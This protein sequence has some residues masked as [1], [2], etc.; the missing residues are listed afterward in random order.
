MI[1]SRDFRRVQQLHGPSWLYSNGSLP[2]SWAHRRCALPGHP[3]QVQHDVW[4]KK[5]QFLALLS[6]V[7]QNNLVQFIFISPRGGQAWEETALQLYLLLCMFC[8]E[9]TSASSVSYFSMWSWFVQANFFLIV[10]HTLSDWGGWVLVTRCF[11]NLQ[12]MTLILW[13]QVLEQAWFLYLVAKRVFSL[14]SE[15]VKLPPEKA[16]SSLTCRVL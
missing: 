16:F 2:A 5:D 7:R 6:Q 13:N 15:C 1:F 8:L 14:N 9:Q 3:P 12:V 4:C 11:L 10:Q